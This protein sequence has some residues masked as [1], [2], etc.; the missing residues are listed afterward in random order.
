MKIAESVDIVHFST[1]VVFTNDLCD[2]RK[3]IRF[4]SFIEGAQL[5]VNSWW[6]GKSILLLALL[7]NLRI[8]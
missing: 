4:C 3:T 5:H 2:T 6:L 1:G 8:A 7:R